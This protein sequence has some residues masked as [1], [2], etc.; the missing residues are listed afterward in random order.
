[1]K[2]RRRADVAEWDAIID[3][4]FALDE[5]MPSFSL[6]EPE[7]ELRNLGGPGSGNFG[8]AGRP[9]Q[10][11][12][13]SVGANAKLAAKL[14]KRGFTVVAAEDLEEAL[15]SGININE[16][17]TA[18]LSE[19]AVE[20]IDAGLEDVKRFSPELYR[21]LQENIG[22]TIGDYGGSAAA[23]AATGRSFHLFFNTSEQPQRDVVAPEFIGN[24]I[25]TKRARDKGLKGDDFVREAYRGITI[26]E[27]GHL[28][29]G[30]NNHVL[31]DMVGYLHAVRTSGRRSGEKS[32]KRLSD[33]ISPYAANA[34]PV[35]AAAEVF[36]AT[37][38]DYPVGSTFHPARDAIRDLKDRP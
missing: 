18:E 17:S 3:R 11:G 27:V 4:A 25:A 2:H 16:N 30:V 29:D 10:V 21:N 34:G 13:S 19:A 26:H 31:S 14:T 9:G 36:A 6:V 7:E 35:E 5:E 24:T 28:V 23:T 15:A 33:D 20:G 32:L 12:G 22:I 38:L 37:L 8:H 1:M